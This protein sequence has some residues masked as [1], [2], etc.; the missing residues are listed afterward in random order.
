MDDYSLGYT[1]CP[2][3]ATWYSEIVEL[4]EK[5]RVTYE[6]GILPGDG[7]LEDQDEMFSEVF[8]SFVERWS[9]RQYNRIWADVRD[10]TKVVLES[11]FGKKGR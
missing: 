1:F 8:Y 5:C 6:T 3:K 10:Y 4:F 9:A 7:S 11:I 2:G